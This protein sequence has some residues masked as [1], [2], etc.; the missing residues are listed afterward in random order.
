MRIHAYLAAEHL[1]V[2]EDFTQKSTEAAPLKRPNGARMLKE[3]CE[4]TMKV[5]LRFVNRNRNGSRGDFGSPR[6]SP[7]DALNSH[8]FTTNTKEM[9][10]ETISPLSFAIIRPSTHWQAET[11]S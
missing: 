4:G 1:P 9:R 2:C 8:D 3:L 7:I 6:H 11:L 5:A 10:D